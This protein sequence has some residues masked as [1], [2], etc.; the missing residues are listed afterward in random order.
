MGAPDPDPTAVYQKAQ[1]LPTHK[2][3]CG[4]CQLSL[5]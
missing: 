2:V 4:G 3:R 5:A 1:G